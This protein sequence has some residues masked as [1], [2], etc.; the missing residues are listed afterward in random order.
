MLHNLLPN[1]KILSTTEHALW[2]YT[3]STSTSSAACACLHVGLLLGCKAGAALGT[4]VVGVAPILAPAEGSR[5]DSS[6][7]MD[8]AYVPLD[9]QSGDEACAAP[10]SAD[11]L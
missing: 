10:P 3:S 2:A 8:Q 5:Q 9:S 1:K 11:R 4:R 6:M 7:A